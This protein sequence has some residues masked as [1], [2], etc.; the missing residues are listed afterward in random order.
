V[1][2]LWASCDPLRSAALAA[3][4]IFTPFMRIDVHKCAIA[5]FLTNITIPMIRHAKT[6]HSDSSS[7]WHS[8]CT[9]A[10]FMQTIPTSCRVE[11]FPPHV[12]QGLLSQMMILLL[13]ITRRTMRSSFDSL[14]AISAIPITFILSPVEDRRSV[15]MHSWTDPPFDGRGLEYIIGPVVEVKASGAL[16]HHPHHLPPAI[17]SPPKPPA[18]KI[19]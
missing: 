14:L 12:S 13:S 15:W 4:R 6:P 8:I 11:T 18:F 17:T 5:V 3:V 2:R 19:L 16:P 7:G 10:P 9:D 1:C